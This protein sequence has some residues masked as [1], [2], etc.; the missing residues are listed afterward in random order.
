MKVLHIISGG[1]VGGSKKHLLSLALNADFKNI[2]VCLIEGELY[3][4]AVKLGLDVRLIKQK[5]RFDLSVLKQIQRIVMDE[6]VDIIN[7][8]GGRANFLGLFLKKSLKKPFVST[9]HSDYLRDYEGNFLKSLIFSNINAY[10][11]KKFD[12]YIAVSDEFKKMLVERGF[13]KNRIFV[14][15][16]GIDFDKVY[17]FELEDVVK[18]YNLPKDKKF[19]SMVARLHPIKGHKFL[20][21]AAKKVLKEYKDVHFLIIG[22]GSIKE[23]L[24]NYVKKLNIEDNVRFLGFQRPDEFLAISSFSVLTSMSESFPLSILEAAKYKKTVV[25]T[26]VGGISDLIEDG[27]NGYLVK[28]GDVDALCQ[29]ILDL[30]KDDLKAKEFGE[31]LY[32]KAKD[33]FSL[34]KFVDG[35]SKIYKK[36]MGE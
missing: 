14:V 5:G 30:L 31:R 35:Y 27:Y 29:K 33:M 23:H 4:E 19:V 24:I 26:L 15:Y 12:Y 22:D 18:K 2:I 9:I 1:E 36:I 6:K 28:Y 8:H 16:N 7:C 34:E 32:D 13:P 20:F 25:S 21:D 11:L 17:S 10:A 3:K